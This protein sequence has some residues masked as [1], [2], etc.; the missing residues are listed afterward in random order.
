MHPP[1]AQAPRRGA[2]WVT[3]GGG[4]KGRL[5][6]QNGRSPRTPKG[7]SGERNGIYI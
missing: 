3:G 1:Y 6:R 2:A 7:R 5:P 4:L